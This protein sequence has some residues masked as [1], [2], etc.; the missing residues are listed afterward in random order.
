MTATPLALYFVRHGETLWSLSGQHTGRT[1]IALTANGEAEAR[2]LQ[3]LLGEINFSRVLTSPR[4]RARRTCDLAGLQAAAKIEPLLAEIDYGDYEGR[5]S[6]DIRKTRPDWNVYRDGSPNGETP[7][8]MYERADHL[9]AQLR[10][11]SG[12]IA[13]FSHGQFGRI[14]AV[15]WIGLPIIAAQHFNLEPAA[16]GILGTSPSHFEVP[17]IALW[18]VT[19]RTLPGATGGNGPMH[20]PG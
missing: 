19:P 4:L 14:L 11:Q 16:V 1:E 9:I 3:A 18:N 7:V 13:L 15:R 6:V 8:Q 10:T 20:G 17:V 12:N 5:R 2:A